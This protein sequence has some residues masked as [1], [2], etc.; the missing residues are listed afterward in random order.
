MKTK[1]K[2]ILL[3]STNTKSL[4][5]FRLDLIKLLIK[6]KFEIHILTNN[7]KDDNLFSDYSQI[8]FHYHYINRSSINPIKEILSIGIIFYCIFA[9]RPKFIIS[10]FLK[11][12]LY[13]GIASIFFQNIKK[14]AF[15]EGLGFLF[16]YSERKLKL[17][18]KVLKFILRYLLVKSFINFSLIFFLNKD[19]YKDLQRFLKIKKIYNY[20]IFGPIGVNIKKI[21]YSKIKFDQK[22]KFI[23]VG[24]FLYEKGLLTFLNA[25]QEC[26]KSN[27]NIEFNIIGT[28]DK[29]NPGNIRKSDLIKFES[30][31]FINFLGFKDNVIRYIRESH[32]LVLPSLREGFPVSIQEA[33]AVGRP[34]ITTNAPGCK[35]SIIVGKNGYLIEPNDSKA[36]LDIMIKMLKDKNSII[37]MGNNARKHAE[38]FYDVEKNNYRFYEKYLK[39]YNE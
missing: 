12:V 16:T 38:A 17:K 34:V 30:N 18:Y 32:V 22:I 37:E 3:I 10:F 28:F 23:F 7:N 1:N 33:M 11:S 39:I 6:K 24:R 4:Y 36:L 21:H 14:Y 5:A 19:D 26:S 15:I 8:R 9:I 2:R 29:F 31:K 13:T 20:S 35:D 27:T 25:A